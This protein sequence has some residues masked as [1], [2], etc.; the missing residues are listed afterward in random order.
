MLDF[1]MSLFGYENI[2]KIK[3]P[4]GYKMPRAE[5]MRCKASFYATTGKFQD[6]III[7]KEKV[8]LDG[9]VTFKL[10]KWIDKK[11]IKVL[12]IDTNPE[13][14]KNAYRGYRIKN[15]ERNRSHGNIKD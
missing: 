3:I 15:K 6:K 10:C 12:K 14:Y 5:K 1:I 2:H 11:Y 8:L 4:S 9:Y 7:N 13:T